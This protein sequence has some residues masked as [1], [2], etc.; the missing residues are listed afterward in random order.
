M[1]KR[2][3][4]LIL[5][6]LSG[7]VLMGI[8]FY[9]VD[10]RIMA[11]T[12][13]QISIFYL[14]LIFLLGFVML[15]VSC[16]KW[17]ILLFSQKLSLKFRYLT[18]SYFIG[19]FFTNFLPTNVGGDVVRGY[20]VGRDTGQQAKSF[21][22]V[23]MERF[24]GAVVL[25][26]WA[27][28]TPLINPSVLKNKPITAIALLSWAY[29]VFIALILF[30]RKFLYRTVKKMFNIRFIWDRAD[31]I[32]NKLKEADISRGLIV[33][34]M[35]I[36]VFFYFLTFLNVYLGYL[37]FGVRV[38]V[39]EVLTYTPIIMVVSILPI[40]IN[41]IGL[42]EG[43]FVYCFLLAGISKE[44]SLSAALLI[45]LKPVLFGMIGG[46]F[47]IFSPKVSREQIVQDKALRSG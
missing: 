5:K 44:A 24:T 18:V 33:R 19:Y 20:L 11:Q 37:T 36:T 46:I 26:L 43:A 41:A 38:P 7:V 15:G 25:L 13:R 17:Q 22:S 27:A 34:V 35:A 32:I 31:R 14:V 2:Q 16:W 39:R 23:F 1:E 3:I 10:W 40:S 47:Y 8:L 9:Q 30:Q 4:L 28:L 29:L 12:L 6:I 42:S 21:W 45:R